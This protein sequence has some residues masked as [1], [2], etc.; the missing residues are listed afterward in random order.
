MK[1]T[2]P[3]AFSFDDNFTLP[4]WVAVKSLI[5]NA[6]RQTR[7]HIFIMYSS[8]SEENIA[9]FSA[10]ANEHAEITFLKIDNRRFDNAPKSVAWPYEVY[11]RLII[12]ELIPQYDKVI[13]SDVDVMF[14]G[15]LS[16]L[17]NQDFNNFQIGA[18]AAER[19]DEL[20]GVHQH[21][22]EYIND[23]IYFSGLIVF[24]NKKCR[25]DKIVDR[26]F[27]NMRRYK[28]RL[29]MFD[30]EV[31]NL[32][33]GK[34][35]PVG[36]EYCV[37]E[38]LYYEKYQTTAEYKFLRNVYSDAEIDA[39]VE[40]PVIVHYAGAI[41]KM[42][43][44]I[45]PAADYYAYVNR[46]PYFDDYKKKRLKKKILRLFNPIWY[47]LSRVTP[48]KNYRKKFRNILRGNY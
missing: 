11:Y 19:T 7:Y 30:L 42:W 6:A 39:A 24:N 2:I 29:K 22:P 15:D 5:D 32:S 14:K 17:Y 34:I 46:S 26:F 10:L 23:L 45:K 48:I 13:Y 16:A 1:N 36:L 43:K 37:L 35:K 9:L 12:P 25:E 27:E 41:V 8:L 40:K 47:I 21:F 38:N 33:C 3:V 20:N 4:A 18:V 28:N 44:K 31:M